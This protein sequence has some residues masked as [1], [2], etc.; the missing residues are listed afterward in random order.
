MIDFCKNISCLN[1]AVC[2]TDFLNYTCECLDESYSECHCELINAQMTM[3]KTM[4][5][6]FAFVAIT[7]VTV[8]CLFFVL[9]DVLKYLFGIDV[10]HNELLKKMKKTT[11]QRFTHTH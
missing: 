1:N 7:A 6:S 5:K 4:S 10:T 8:L 11:I 2:R 3:K 9:I